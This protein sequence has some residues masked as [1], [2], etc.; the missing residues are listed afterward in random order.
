MNNISPPSSPGTSRISVRL[1]HSIAEV[2]AAQRLR[3]Q[4]FYEEFGAQ[5]SPEILA[6]GKDFDIYDEHA[7]HLIAISDDGSDNKDII[8]T[9]RLLSAAAAQKTHGFYS[10][11]EYDIA[12]LTQSGL[13]LLELG[14]SCVGQAYR[15]RSVLQQLW[16]GIVNHVMAHKIDAMFGCASFNGTNIRELAPALSYLHHFHAA[17]PDF[18]A[19]VHANAFVDM[20]IIPKDQL[21]I[22]EAFALLPPLLKGY[23]RAGAL[24][25]EGAFIDRTF[26]TTDVFVV[27]PTERIARKYR[28]HYF[29]GN[30][31]QTILSKYH[32]ESCAGDSA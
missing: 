22:R 5:A 19:R 29:A 2:E 20:N 15:T 10:A 6:A 27:L 30:Q 14:R 8:G 32:Q 12:C 21:D 28:D 3:Y 31:S 11:Q 18:K 17:P 26:Q 23:I 24:I 1:A 13:N 16:Q 4:V 7:A 25:G 9:Y